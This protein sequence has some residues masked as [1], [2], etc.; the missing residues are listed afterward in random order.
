MKFFVDKDI[1]KKSLSFQLTNITGKIRKF[2][3]KKVH[4]FSLTRIGQKEKRQM[5]EPIETVIIRVQQNFETAGGLN[6]VQIEIEDNKVLNIFKKYKNVLYRLTPLG[7]LFTASVKNNTEQI[8]ST[9]RE[10]N[11]IKKALINSKIYDLLGIIDFKKINIWEEIKGQSIW[12]NATL[13]EQREINTNK[14]L[15]FLFTARTL[16]DLL[17]FSISLLDDNNKPITF[18]NN[19]E[20]NKYF[21]F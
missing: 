9:S 20:K 4:N 12:I 2:K 17:N 1:S 11:D 8:F 13:E 10:L 18:E 5:A 3:D 15:C 16:N 7:I 21:K 19:E 6:L 14:H